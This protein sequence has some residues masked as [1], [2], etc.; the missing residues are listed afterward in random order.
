MASFTAT[1]LVMC[2]LLFLR[3]PQL[4]RFFLPTLPQVQSF[5]VISVAE[6]SG[7]IAS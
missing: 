5:S 7:T 1:V 3:I 6:L 2:L 4:E